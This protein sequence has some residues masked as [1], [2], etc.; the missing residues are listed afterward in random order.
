MC[1]A[2]AVRFLKDNKIAGEVILADN[3]ST[4]SSAEIAAQMGAVIVHVEQKG[5]GMALREGFLAAKGKYIIM[6]DSDDSYD[7]INLMLF[8]EKLRE[9][10]DLSY[11]ESFQRW[12]TEGC[13]ALA[14]SL[15]WKSCSFFSWKTVL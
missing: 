8:V 9:G 11:G 5:Y 4:D 3:G 15:Y 14:S 13:N 7:L 12:N 1:V 10:Y 6:A 2:K